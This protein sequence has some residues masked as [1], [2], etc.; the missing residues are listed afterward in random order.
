MP[1]LYRYQKTSDEYT[2]YGPQGE[3]ITELCTLPDGFTYISVPEDGKL[4][5]VQP[6]QIKVEEV[7][8]TDELKEQ[9][10]TASPH[11]QLIYTRMQE[12]IR[13]KYCSEDE[14]YFTRISVGALSGVYTMQPGEPELIADYQ[15]FIE[16]VRQ[17]GKDERAKLGL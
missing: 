16:S 10:K 17:W 1:K 11:C 13:A 3:G 14:M 2:T 6:K 7:I 12:K 5:N 4:S 8:L 9:I 15:I